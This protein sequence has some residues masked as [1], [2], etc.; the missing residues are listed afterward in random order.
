MAM[1]WW[2]IRS[3]WYRQL[4]DPHTRGLRAIDEISNAELTYFDVVCVH[5]VVPAELMVAVRAQPTCPMKIS[6][7]TEAKYIAA[8]N[9][10]GLL[11]AGSCL[12]RDIPPPLRQRLVSFSLAT[13]V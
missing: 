4:E 5:A 3:S 13:Q 10:F 1:R 8:Q 12:P 7:V 6:S 11:E 2:D 9:L